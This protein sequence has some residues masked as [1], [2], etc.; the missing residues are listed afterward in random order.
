VRFKR[1]RDE[2]PKDEGSV[3]LVRDPNKCI[4]CGDC[5]RY[6]SEIQG[7]G[8]IDFAFRGSDVVVSPAFGKS[9]GSVDCVNC[10][11]CAAVCP[12]G[13]I[14]PRSP[15]EAVWQALDD[16]DAVVV[17]QVA[18]AVRVAI[19]ERFGLAAGAD[20]TGKLVTA[21]RML[22]FG[23]VYD[24]AF[25]ADLTVAEEAGELLGRLE[26]GEKLPLFT[27]CCPAGSSTP[28]SSS[29]S[30]CRASARACLLSR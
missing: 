25:G 30:C 27:S 4:L 19:G 12:T 14:V 17:A 26:R 20:A 29:R 24:T 13:A 23:R 3:A 8:A 18:P 9:L 6:C 28:S 5:V 21:L 15:A 7:V 22:G 1:L 11:Q 2:R 16:P 10:G